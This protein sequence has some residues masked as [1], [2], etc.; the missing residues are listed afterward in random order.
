MIPARFSYSHT[1][2]LL[3]LLFLVIQ[4]PIRPQS[5]KWVYFL[6]LAVPLWLAP[7]SMTIV[8]KSGILKKAPSNF[9]FLAALLL[10]VAYILPR[11]LLSGVIAMLWLLATLYLLANYFLQHKK[12]SNRA[13]P[14]VTLLC[15]GAAFLFLPV[16]AAWT[17]ADRLAWHPLGFDPI[18]VLLT[19]AHFHYAG[20]L[21]PLVT[22]LVLRSSDSRL[23]NWIGGGIIT[24]V[25]LVALGITAS[26]FGLPPFLEFAA[27]IVLALAGLGVAG[28]HLLQAFDAANKER[29]PVLCWT[30]GG[31]TLG[32]GMILAF[33]YGARYYYPI[34]WLTIPWMY[35]VHGTL[36][37]TGLILLL[38]GW[39]F[40]T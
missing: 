16:G 15:F 11:G 1:G 10:M 28:L 9:L 30:L 32:T 12:F 20:F 21:L 8:I 38:L 31:L 27:V 25:P 23:G 6:M 13:L 34:A 7:Q 14:S 4:L 5:E 22:G 39:R 24:G 19:A 33:L 37:A 26:Q 18:I 29:I 3:W 2:I 36:N 35:A 40:E 17:A